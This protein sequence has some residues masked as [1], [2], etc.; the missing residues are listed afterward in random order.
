[1]P[2]SSRG[3]EPIGDRRDGEVAVITRFEGVPAWFGKVR[4]PDLQAGV[5]PLGS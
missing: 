2:E 3:P 4:R 1:M 5:W